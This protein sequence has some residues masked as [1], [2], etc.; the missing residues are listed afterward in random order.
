MSCKCR[1]ILSIMPG[2]S[3][4]VTALIGARGRREPQHYAVAGRVWLEVGQLG[5][6]AV[7]DDADAGG[8]SRGMHA[9]KTSSKIA[10]QGPAH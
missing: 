4:S 1:L 3:A 2:S 10:S 7:D 9:S 6:L 5:F 8:D